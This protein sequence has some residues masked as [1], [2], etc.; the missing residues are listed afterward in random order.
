MILQ[1]HS[2][3]LI[4]LSSIKSLYPWYYA[5]SQVSGVS[6]KRHYC[7]YIYSQVVWVVSSKSSRANQ[8]RDIEHAYEAMSNICVE[9]KRSKQVWQ[10]VLSNFLSSR[11]SK[12]LL[13]HLETNKSIKDCVFVDLL[14]ELS[15]SLYKQY[16]GCIDANIML[17][18]ILKDMTLY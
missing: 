2:L 15:L 9:P 4:C 8:V 6:W 13:M 3:W 16:L 1:K 7:W 14:L 12:E 18:P 17:F 11:T 5:H 10:L